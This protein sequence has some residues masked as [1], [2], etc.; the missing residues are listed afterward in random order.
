IDTRLRPNGAAGLLVTSIDAFKR[1][2]LREGD[3]SA[4]LWEHQALTR[5]RF[6]AGDVMIGQKFE[7]IRSEVLAQPRDEQLL[8]QE[9]LSMR[10]KVSDGHPNDSGM[11]DIKHDS[12]GMVDIEFIVQ[13][14]V[15]R[16][17]AEHPKLVGNWGNIALLGYA[18]EDQLIPEDLAHSVANAYRLYREYQHRI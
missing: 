2:Q 12:G 13:Y 6:C 11:F 14:L 7:E 15:L 17:S 3:N 9:V 1:Y 4:W 8:K 10:K 16:F 18:A 5:A